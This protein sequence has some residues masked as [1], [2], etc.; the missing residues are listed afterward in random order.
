M[1]NLSFR[2]HAP[3]SRQIVGLGQIFYCINISRS[4]KL[5][6]SFFNFLKFGGADESLGTLVAKREFLFG[7][8]LL[9]LAETFNRNVS[10]RQ[11]PGGWQSKRNQEKLNSQEFSL[12]WS[13][14]FFD[15]LVYQ[16][17][18]RK[19]LM[20]F[21]IEQAGMSFMWKSNYEAKTSLS[22]GN[23]IL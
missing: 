4:R 6:F 1:W 8:G 23:S 14:K 15:V 16:R 9:F 11:L 7:K 10:A 12:E 5:I 18:A 2:C 20:C 3:T 13:K 22:Q 17:K 21:R 19:T